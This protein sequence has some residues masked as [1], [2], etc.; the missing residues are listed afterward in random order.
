ME[1]GPRRGKLRQ[2]ASSAFTH[3]ENQRV[4]DVRL[5]ARL[6]PHE[7]VRVEVVRE[8]SGRLRLVRLVGQLI[9]ILAE[10]GT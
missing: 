8:V 1:N 7:A 5:N 6:V 2:Q 4:I 3:I 10:E 9:R